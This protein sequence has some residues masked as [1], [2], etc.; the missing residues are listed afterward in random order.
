MNR[1]E[2]ANG[3]RNEIMKGERER[4]REMFVIKSM[5]IGFQLGTVERES[6]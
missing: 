2:R 3:D 4:E 5:L 6:R 1:E